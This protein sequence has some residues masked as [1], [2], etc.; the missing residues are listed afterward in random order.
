ML[1]PTRFVLSRKKENEAT[2]PKRGVFGLFERIFFLRGMGEVQNLPS[3]FPVEIDYSKYLGLNRLD[4][5]RWE[6]RQSCY[7]SRPPA[8]TPLSV[9][10]LQDSPPFFF[11]VRDLHANS[12]R[13]AG[14]NDSSRNFNSSLS[15]STFS[16][17]IRRRG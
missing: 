3:P 11:R 8:L 9:R 5:F 4:L 1:S 6:E 10:C 16:S 13:C 15:I 2:V 14:D 17:N 7:V 12:N